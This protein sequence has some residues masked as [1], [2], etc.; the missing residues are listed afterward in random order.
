MDGLMLVATFL[1]HR[2]GRA[3]RTTA[4]GPSSGAGTRGRTLA[5][6]FPYPLTTRD[7]GKTP[8]V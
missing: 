1:P 2:R 8:Q 5:G 7:A 3:G 6:M 4:A